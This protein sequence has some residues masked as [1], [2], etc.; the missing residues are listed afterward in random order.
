M[1]TIKYKYEQKLLSF[2]NVK[3]S[4]R[5]NKKKAKKFFFKRFTIMSNKYYSSN[6]FIKKNI[7]F[8]KKIYEIKVPG[9]LFLLKKIFNN[10]N[11][12][13]Q[14]L[15]DNIISGSFTM[16]VKFI[17]EKARLIIRNKFNTIFKNIFNFFFLK[18]L[19]KKL[20]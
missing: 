9:K 8:K 20:I 12:I 1:K 3:N 14:F 15:I 11:N 2:L 13:L 16:N 7:I 19:K 5:R 18:L 10:E 17:S 4:C 6:C